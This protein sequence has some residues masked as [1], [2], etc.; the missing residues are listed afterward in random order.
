MNNDQTLDIYWKFNE[1]ASFYI[2]ESFH[3][4]NEMMKYMVA[5]IIFPKIL[6][7]IDPTD[8]DRE[9]A[10]SSN[11]PNDPI[12]LMR[13]NSSGLSEET[14]T[15]MSYSWAACRRAAAKIPNYYF[16]N[17]THCEC[18]ELLGH[19]N[20]LCFLLEALTNR[21]LLFLNQIKVIDNFSY[22]KLENEKLM[23]IL[24]YL[25]KGNQSNIAFDKISVLYQLRN[26][27]VHYTPK[28]LKSIS[29]QL[30]ELVKIW[31]QVILIM[32]HFENK[33]QFAET[34]Y[35]KQLKQNVEEFK[36]KWMTNPNKET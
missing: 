19:V 33:E 20:N 30:D 6:D 11:I 3:Y 23:T 29:I 15:M 10:K 7:K 4:A 27:S 13:C 21:H 24:L 32:V 26:K 12:D 25:F 34:S 36:D 1:A 31:E 35:S 9:I 14:I 18:V 28:N 2:N 16:P 17:N 5:L 22:N 8:K